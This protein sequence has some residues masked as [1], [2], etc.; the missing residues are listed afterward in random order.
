MASILEPVTFDPPT[1]RQELNEFD[2]LLK[3]NSDLKEREDIVPFFKTRKHLTA[4][5]GTLYLRVAVATEVCFE[6]DISGN[7]AA[8]VLLGS[9]AANQFC[10]VE[11]E[12]GEEDAIFKKQNRKNP[13][14]SA[15]F[16][17]AFSQIVDWFWALEDQRG[18]QDF[19]T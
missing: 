11:F 1:F 5:I 3:S 6:F 19:R 2:T 8:D 15:R 14:W 9:R 17:H 10:I 18:S 7:F 13:E 16:E 4:Y 12:P